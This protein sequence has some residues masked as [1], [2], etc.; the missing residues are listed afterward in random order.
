V[1]RVLGFATY[2]NK[3][4]YL[5]CIWLLVLDEIVVWSSRVYDIDTNFEEAEDEY[6][7]DIDS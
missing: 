4:L 3:H 5:I 1:L 6:D 2:L 7:K